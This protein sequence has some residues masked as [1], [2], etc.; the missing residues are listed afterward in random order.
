ML[1]EEQL[2]EI[3]SR[4]AAATPGP[5][6]FADGDLEGFPGAVDVHTARGV[7]VCSMAER[8]NYR[9]SA[10]FVAAA[11]GDVPRLAAEVRRLRARVAEL[12]AD[13]GFDYMP[14]P[15]ISSTEYRMVPVVGT[16]DATGKGQEGGG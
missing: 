9:E 11:R 15:P 2:I 3:E 13:G 5:W 4:C 12:E 1:S 10:E 6:V 7:G 8:G 16:A 14:V